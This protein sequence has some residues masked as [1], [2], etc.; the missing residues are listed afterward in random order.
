MLNVLLDALALSGNCAEQQKIVSQ[1]R[2]WG[3]AHNENPTGLDLYIHHL[4][5]ALVWRGCVPFP[6]LNDAFGLIVFPNSMGLSPQH[7]DSDPGTNSETSAEF[8]SLCQ[9][10]IDSGWVVQTVCKF[11]EYKTYCWEL[12][13]D[14]PLHSWLPV[15]PEGAIPLLFMLELTVHTYIEDRSIGRSRTV[16]YFPSYEVDAVTSTSWV[17]V[18]D[19]QGNITTRLRLRTDLHPWLQ[20]LHQNLPY[21]ELS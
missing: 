13:E 14:S 20:I 18:K 1:L 3:I 6:V 7:M 10:L 19:A 16:Y 12:T 9:F 17:N 11:A 15:L 21:R 8:I 5:E 4:L 2:L